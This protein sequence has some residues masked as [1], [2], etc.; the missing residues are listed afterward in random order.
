MGASK[1]ATDITDRKRS[2]AQIAVLAREAE[3]RAK[4]LLANMK[5]VVHLSQAGTPNGLKEAIE[6][7][8]VALANVHSLFVQSRWRG[9]E[10]SNLVEQELSPYS[11][12]G[13]Q[14][15]RIDGPT[16]MLKPDVA[17]AIAVALHELA[18]TPQ[19]TVLYRGRKVRFTSSGRARLMTGSCS[20]GPRR[21]ARLSTC[22]PTRGLAPM[23]SG[24]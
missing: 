10:L 20:A 3:H 23:L 5:A 17:Q 1:I 13:E 15:T 12:D 19:N 22:Q 16:V 21:E 2:E 7:R 24:P 9:A 18:P 6:S 4:N 14:R 8:I 11:H